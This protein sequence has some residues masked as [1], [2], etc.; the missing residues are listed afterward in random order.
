MTDFNRSR[1]EELQ[2]VREEDANRYNRIAE[3][4]DSR[5]F[6]IKIAVG[7][8][9]TGAMLSGNVKN[10]RDAVIIC[11]TMLELI[12]TIFDNALVPSIVGSSTKEVHDSSRYRFRDESER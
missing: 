1:E 8:H 6:E 4:K 11:D 12:R 3:S 2:K 5:I 10:L 9:E 7:P